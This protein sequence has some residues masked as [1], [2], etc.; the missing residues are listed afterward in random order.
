METAFYGIRIDPIS[1]EVVAPEGVMALLAG[2]KQSCA[3]PL[4]EALGRGLQMVIASVRMLA[5]AY[6]E[7]DQAENDFESVE[8]DLYDRY[9]KV[10]E[11]CMKKDISKI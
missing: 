7:L 6:K 10:S 8:Q 4:D 1:Y 5:R 2:H 11:R 3:D 9:C